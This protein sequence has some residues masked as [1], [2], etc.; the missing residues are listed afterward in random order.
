MA[1]PHP[2][3]REGLSYSYGGAGAARPGAA[4]PFP[5]AATP[6]PPLGDIPPMG[7]GLSISERGSQKHQDNLPRAAASRH[8]LVTGPSTDQ[9]RRRQSCSNIHSSSPELL[10]PPFLTPFLPL[11]ASHAGEGAP[12]RL[13]M[14]DNEIQSL[15]FGA[16]PLPVC[17]K[18]LSS[19]LC[20]SNKMIKR[21]SSWFLIPRCS[22]SCARPRALFFP[23]SP[24]SAAEV[25]GARS[26][27]RRAG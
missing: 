3:V 26:R 12:R 18:K 15:R 19:Q 2:I 17:P 8:P 13:P 5:G 6:I 21:S 24:V 4:T 20:G 10:L 9:E 22:N 1:K 7:P 14:N 25:T 11:P 27:R 16:F 23:P